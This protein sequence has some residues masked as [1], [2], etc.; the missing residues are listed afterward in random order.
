[1]IKVNIT[2]GIEMLELPMKLTGPETVVYPTLVWDEYTVILVDAGGPGSLENIKNSMKKAGVPFEKLDK[3]IITHQDIDHIG[4]V[5]EIINEL[6]GVE[7]FSHL[8][9]K[10]YIQ[11]EKKLVRLNSKF[12]ERI[13]HLNHDEKEKVLEIFSTTN[14]EVNRTLSDG[15]KLDCYGG[16]TVIHTPGHTPGHICLYCEAGKTLIVGDAMN[17]VDGQLTGPNPQILNYEEYKKAVKSL[18]KLEG[19]DVEY[20]ITYHGGRY[21]GDPDSI[22][23]ELTGEFLGND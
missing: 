12:M 15:E 23:Q 4:G 10:P 19:L 17:I 8:L 7:V 3:I 1:V 14:A 11:G 21:T 20:V 9:D 18:K 2:S 6:P 16:I 5:K 22:I 13:N